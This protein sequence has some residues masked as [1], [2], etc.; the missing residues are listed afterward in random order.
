MKDE[1]RDLSQ[2]NDRMN[3]WVFNQGPLFH[4]TH[5]G[6]GSGILGRIISGFVKLLVVL[7]I[8]A[9]LFW[10]FLTFKSGGKEAVTERMKETIRAHFGAEEATMSVINFVDGQ[11]LIDKLTL[12]G[13]EASS[14][15]SL[16]LRGIKCAK[17]PLDFFGKDW[18]A[19]PI[20][21]SNLR[22]SLRAGADSDDQASTRHQALFK[23]IEGIQFRS[24]TIAKCDLSWGYGTYTRGS[25]SGAKMV[26]TQPSAD[27]W[28][29]EL[30]EGDFSQTWVENAKLEAVT[31]TS[32]KEGNLELSDGR[33]KLG[34]GQIDIDG[35]LTVA[36]IPKLSG[37][38]EAQNLNIARLMPDELKK[39]FEGRVSGKGTLGGSPNGSSGIT[40][41]MAMILSDE[42]P[43]RVRSRLPLIEAL[44]SIDTNRSYYKVE[45]DRGGFTFDY[46]AGDVK[47]SDFE[48]RA[49]GL[50]S[51][52]GEFEVR[53]PTTSEI[54]VS[55]GRRESEI[56]FLL[57]EQAAEDAKLT[58][59]AAG[60]AT[61]ADLFSQVRRTGAVEQQTLA[62]VEQSSALSLAS[63]ARIIGDLLIRLQRN[64]F[65]E[66][67]L[68]AEK[69]PA[70]S[71][72]EA[73]GVELQLSLSEPLAE[74]TQDAAQEL[75]ELSGRVRK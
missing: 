27:E 19:G 58:L 72:A 22:A 17:P 47:V 71:D 45:F 10:A 74:V 33:L 52:T 25:L 42:S 65:S 75:V 6:S 3:A 35:Q 34:Q 70:T 30:S 56:D 12:E 40:S 67:P 28:V 41:K 37:K 7:T 38:I 48:V 73:D 57:T 61:G 31:V 36:D 21:V 20:E 18:D 54:A 16:E 62:E 32:S 9:A 49:D 2:F 43:V 5:G 8:C 14:F 44:R 51:V 64:V 11:L 4:L 39:Q 1:E 23:P 66:A 50:M 53:R 63:G 46:K 68:L 60:K 69:Y 59:G 29:A 13:G 55:L 26:L 15:D 24:I